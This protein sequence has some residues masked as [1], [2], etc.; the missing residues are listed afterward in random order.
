MYW[1]SNRKSRLPS[2]K[3]GLPPYFYFRFGHYCSVYKL[4]LPVRKPSLRRE[5]CDSDHA[6]C[7]G[8]LEPTSTD[9]VVRVFTLLK[10]YAYRRLFHWGRW[11]KH[12]L[13]KS[14]SLSSHRH[15]IWTTNKVDSAWF[16]F[17]NFSKW[18]VPL[19]PKIKILFKFLKKN[20]Q[21]WPRFH[22]N[23]KIGRGWGSP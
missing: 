18:G 17:L 12:F 15:Q 20:Y 3:I 14:M 6:E 7:W 23:F 16:F 5:S 4:L 10:R 19:T 13:Q 1:T 22:K 8:V 9:S 21:K 11:V 2:Q